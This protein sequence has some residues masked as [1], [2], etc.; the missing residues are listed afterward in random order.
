MLLTNPDQVLCAFEREAKRGCSA[1]GSPRPTW[2]D[3]AKKVAAFLQQ[4]APIVPVLP[5]H[6]ANK[7]FAVNKMRA[8]LL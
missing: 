4:I 3:S 5:T 6:P 2:L 7:S 8:M 1:T